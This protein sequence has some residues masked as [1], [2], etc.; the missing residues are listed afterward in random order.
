MKTVAA[1]AALLPSIALAGNF[2]TCLLDKLPAV[3]N[4]VAAHAVYQSCLDAHV[5]GLASVPQGSARGWLGYKSGSECTLKKAADTRSM[6]AATM[7]GVAC[8]RL[9]DENGPWLNY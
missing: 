3:Q 6:R 8:R 4:D 7:I 2:A 9:Y 1:L 5:G